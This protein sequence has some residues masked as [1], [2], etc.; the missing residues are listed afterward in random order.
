M[1]KLN[2]ITLSLF[3]AL[4]TSPAWAEEE[5]F[6]TNFMFGGLKGEKVSRYQI[7][8]TKPMAGVYEM[9]VYVNK[10]WRGTY[11]VNIQDD[12]DSTC[13]SP[14]L[15]ASL[16][17][18][19]TTQSTTVENECIALKTVVHGGSVSYDTDAFNL[20]LSVPQAYVLEYEAGYASPETWDR[21]INAFYTSYYASEYYSHYK[22]GG[23]E[24]NTYANFVSGLNLL[25][26]QLHSNAN[27]SKS[28]N[29]A[30]KWQ[31]NTL[32]LERDFPA[33]LGTMRLGE[34]YTSGDMFDTVR[35]RG[36]RFWRDMQMLP[37]SKQNFAPV[38]R[39]VAQSNAL[40]TVEQNGFIVYQKEVPPGPFVFE[41]LQLAGGGADLDVS[42]KEADG[43]VSRFIVP[44]S[45]VPNMVQP[46]VAKYDFAAGRSR[47]EG[48]SQQTD[49]LQGTYQYGV[50]NLLTLYGGTMLASDYRSF[51]LGTGWNTLIGAV[52]VDGTLSHS[53]Q[54]N[55]DVFDGESYQ[56]AWNKY[57]PQS[58]T[59]FSLAAYRYSSRDY[60]T[61]NDHVWAN[62]RDNY[63]RDDDDI[64]DIADYYENDFGRKNTFTLNI[65]QTLPDGWGY[66]TAS[67]LWRDY[68]GRSGTGKDYQLSYS[69]T[70]QRLSFTLSAT[71]TYDSD[72][73]EDKRFN[74]YLSIPLT[75]GVKENGGNR[76]IHLSNST[77]FDDQGYEANNTSLSGTFGNR[78]QFNY[79]TNLSQQR[80]EH[81]TTFGGSVTWNAPL[82][83]VGGSYSQSNQY[84]QVGGNIQGG[85]V[86]WA[87]GVHLASRLNDTIAIINAPYLE[88]AAVQGRPYLRTN[89]KGYAVFEALTPYRQNFISLDVSESESDV[90]LLGNRKV[91]VPYRG[92]VV[93]V[94]FETETSKPFYFLARRA[95][96]EPLTFGYEVEDDEGNNVGL[97]GQGSRVFIRTEK[98]PVSV[99]VATDK[100]QGL[101]CKITFD[102]QIDENNVYIC[103]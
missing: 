8:S 67:A 102:K 52:S 94:D 40:V 61:F 58:A 45:S 31:S 100:Q 20:Y 1:E 82:A 56:I 9:D 14:D 57:L 78:D 65:N 37:H 74:I 99:K 96:G 77:T 48:A 80:Q 46:G 68:W 35:F 79:T 10:E 24:K 23:S 72:N 27:F 76:D 7:D 33:V 38:V 63:R 88:G 12:P 21:G 28:D 59:H 71:Q 16:G 55:G 54:D 47:I 85:L 87:D 13:I 53:K 93:V 42:V 75:W 11:E 83:T 86:A 66:F 34:Q 64:Y 39:G 29:S 22:S 32:Y 43:T 41:D 30:G 49:F 25:G 70:W 95:D 15:I 5:T 73:R 90:A 98:V 18:K 62:N 26:W 89:A 50:N 101:F 91:T 60:R 92:A 6:D 4:L 84:H 19:F 97:V 103:R 51:T 17:I 81:Q 3:A 36:V 69:N 2:A 44:Y